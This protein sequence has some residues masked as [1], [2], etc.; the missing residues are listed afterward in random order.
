MSLIEV[1]Q[2]PVADLVALALVHFIWQGAAIAGALVL[3]VDLANIRPAT[4]RYALSLSAL[5]LMTI[6]PLATLTWLSVNHAPI[7]TPAAIGSIDFEFATFA[8]S[9]SPWQRSVT[10]ETVQP[11]V[12]FAWL[13]GVAIFGGRLVVGAV[14]LGRLRRDRLPLSPKL[15]GVVERLGRRFSMPARPLVFLS[16][17]IVDAMA[18]GILRPIVLVPAAWATEM[19]LEMLEAVIAHE[20]AHL[21][22]RDLWVNIL[23]RVLETLLFYHPAVWWLSRRL[24][25]ERE[26]CADEL[27]VEATGQRLVYVQTLEQ[28]ARW[29]QADVRPAL[30]AFLRGE[31]NM[32]LLERVRNVLGIAGSERSRLWPAGIVALALPMGLWVLSLCL[33]GSL[34]QAA[35]ADDDDERVIKREG[36][37]GERRESVERKLLLLVG[38]GDEKEERK[39]AA[40]DARVDELVELV[41]R[42]TVRVE[43]MQAEL[44]SLRGQKRREGEEKITDR[45]SDE[46]VKEKR[47]TEEI[48]E[49]EAR[50]RKARAV[51]EKELAIRRAAEE[52]EEAARI[53]LRKGS[54]GEGREREER[55]KDEAILKAVNEKRRIAEEKERA[56]REK[57][58]VQVELVEKKVRD[59]AALKA[60]EALKSRDADV[61]ELVEK[62]Q[63][64]IREKEALLGERKVELKDKLPMLKR[65]PKKEGDDGEEEQKGR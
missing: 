59:L 16:A 54:E 38:E 47:A 42:L 9:S 33:F 25:I 37:R 18:I 26:L 10:M 45:R 28:V 50:E 46:R 60:L 8:E 53:K 29:R 34:S 61:R 11:Y 35:I 6:C 40:G 23:Q 7:R 22:R 39:R 12:L 57:A 63:A 3:I 49:A 4:T 52:K 2:H 58:G 64:V 20:L 43:R 44:D 48:S 36:D 55:E 51:A 15:A 65:T 31:K 21:R 32:R 41:K 1:I 62:L 5:L 30:A 27:A 14:G 56:A 24:R 19:P 13:G 17:R